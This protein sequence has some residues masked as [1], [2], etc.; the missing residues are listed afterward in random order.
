MRISSI[1]QMAQEY[2]VQGVVGALLVALIFAVGYFFI[3]R[4]LLNG[5]KKLKLKQLL[6]WGI[7]FVYG[8]V[9]LQATLGSRG[10][11]YQRGA[12]W[13]PFSSYRE[14]WNSFSA[15][16]WRNL[17]LNIMLFV[18]LGFLLPLVSKKCRR[19]W[20][21][22]GMGLFLTL[23][24]EGVQY[25]FRR[26]IFEMDDII[27]NTVGTMIGFG[28]ISILSLI[29]AKVRRQKAL[30]S[31]KGR[32][33]IIF[34]LPLVGGVVAFLIAFSIYNAKEL[35]N[36]P[37]AYSMRQNMSA[38]DISTT[39]DFSSVPTREWVYKTVYGTRT[40]SLQTANAFLAHYGTSVD[41]ARID[42]YSDTVVYWAKDGSRNIWVNDKGL[43]YRFNDFSK[44]DDER[45][46]GLDLTAVATIL[47]KYDIAVPADA[48]LTENE[49]GRY[50]IEVTMADMGDYFLE[51]S[52]YCEI[53]DGEI[54]SITNDLLRLEPYQDYELISKQEAYEQIVAGKFKMYG[55][56]DSLV[57]NDVELNYYMDSKGYYQPGYD[58]SG[59]K[60]EGAGAEKIN[61]SIPAVK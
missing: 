12:I 61:I 37:I 43:T 31:D 24:I 35:G 28:I 39:E 14:A 52:L 18:P 27:N 60:G 25:V 26:G 5:T 11:M 41:E 10:S 44:S 51:G 4:K 40:E 8:I 17:I 32:T 53:V 21:T 6:L 55:S 9:V 29:Y 22:Y 13:Q 49:G 30:I 57:I 58:F 34:Q 16:S 50:Q 54:S 45:E 7:L 42:A 36:L 47:A 56:L 15:V 1:I 3:Y 33:V 38:V 20:V 23:L 48:S 2:I 19:F 46:L 59:I